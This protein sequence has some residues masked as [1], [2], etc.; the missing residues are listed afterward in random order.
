MATDDYVRMTVE[1]LTLDPTTKTPIV[2]LKAEATELTLPI[3]I[4][5]LE[6]TSLAT[7]LEGIELARPMTH[8]L[9]K[10]LVEE[11]GAR[12]ARVEVTSLKDNTFYASIHIEVDGGQR[13][14]DS[15]PSD[16]ISLALRAGCP[17]YVARDV[18]E[19]SAIPAEP[20]GAVEEGADEV[21][22]AEAEAQDISDVSRDEWSEILEK[23]DPSDFKYKM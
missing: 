7:E 21:D 1:G 11:A 14:V 5:L 4:G 3:W 20:P 10:T 17:I 16:A 18:L 15:R 23:L 2:V 6:A 12:V 9:L 13:T 22:A 19:S 8:D